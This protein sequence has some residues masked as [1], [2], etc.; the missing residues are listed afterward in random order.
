[1]KPIRQIPAA[2]FCGALFGLGLALSGMLDPKRVRGFLDL[3]GAFDPSLAF[4]LFGAVAASA[5]GHQ[6]S[7]RLPRPLLGATFHL[8]ASKTIDRPLIA[9]AAIF[10]IGWGMAGL[11]PGPAIASLSLGLIPVCVFAASMIV[12]VL[13]HDRLLTRHGGGAAPAAAPAETADVA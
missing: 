10:G 12:G 3:F 7:R 8:P 5:V 13:L 9:G 11:C 6:L 2:L 4:V 1:M